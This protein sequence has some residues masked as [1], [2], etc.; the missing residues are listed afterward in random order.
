MGFG[1]PVVRQVLD[2]LLSNGC[3]GYAVLLLRWTASTRRLGHLWW[4]RLVQV[5][6]FQP[7]DR[8]LI[9]FIPKLQSEVFWGTLDDFERTIIRILE[10]SPSSVMS[11]EHEL[12]LFEGVR[13]V[14]LDFVFPVG[15]CWDWT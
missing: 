8:D 11:D 13:N 15:R 4:L 5:G 12:C 1:Q 3:F 7:V 6:R 14:G 9:L 10:R 2:I